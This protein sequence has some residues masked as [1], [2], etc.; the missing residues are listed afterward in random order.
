MRHGL[1]VAVIDEFS[2]AG[3]YMPGLTRVPLEETA[4]IALRAQQAGRTCRSIAEFA[5]DRLR[6]ELRAAVKNRPWAA[7]RRD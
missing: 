4:G 7:P 3:V 2:V 6:E 5:I 1:G